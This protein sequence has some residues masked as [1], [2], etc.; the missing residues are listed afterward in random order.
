MNEPTY[1][2]ETLARLRGKL[3]S[4][5][6]EADE[7]VLLDDILTIATEVTAVDDTEDP[8]SGGQ[9]TFS[10]EFAASRIPSTAELI[11]AYAAAHRAHPILVSQ[12]IHPASASPAL[13]SRHLVSRAHP[14]GGPTG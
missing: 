9:P 13:V 14:H 5:G 2:D 4:C 10:D 3:D 12:A 1:S 8:D 7:R 6:L 11:K